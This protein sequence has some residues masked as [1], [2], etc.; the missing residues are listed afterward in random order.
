[1][2]GAPV[3][4][5]RSDRRRKTTSARIIDG[6]IEVRI[7]AFLSAEQELEVVADL[8]RRVDRARSAAAGVDLTARAAE[9]SARYALPDAE[10][11]RWVTNQSKRWG[12]CTPSSRKI[13]IS[14]RLQRVPEYVLDA[15]LVH[16]L[17]HLAVPDH[18]PA[19][20]DLERRYELWDRAEGFLEAMS[21]GCAADRYLSD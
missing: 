19:F 4:V 20:I 8:V 16:E 14:T 7:P 6:T 1:M 10:D 3:R 21:L 15:V 11:V 12:S 2:D 9:L 13:R 17:A 5:V 18:G